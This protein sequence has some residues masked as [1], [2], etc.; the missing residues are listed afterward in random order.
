[1]PMELDLV[2]FLG[3]QWNKY[4]KSSWYSNIVMINRYKGKYGA[5]ICL[6]FDFNH[7][8]Q[9][10]LYRMMFYLCYPLFHIIYILKPVF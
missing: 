3:A 7:R 8:Y 5:H 2:C 10:P 6:P 9:K 4:I 1:M